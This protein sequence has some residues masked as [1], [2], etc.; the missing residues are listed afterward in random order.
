M[1]TDICGLCRRD[2]NLRDSHYL[3]A[4]LYEV[5]RKSSSPADPAPVIV[6]GDRGTAVFNSNQVS[7]PFLCSDCEDK[8]SKNGERVV[9][10]QCYRDEST[11]KLRDAMKAS[12]PSTSSSGRH[13]FYGNQ[14]RPAINPIAYYY[15]AL[16][17]FWRGSS[18]VWKPPAPNF[19]GV[20]G[21]RYQ[22]EVRKYLLGLDDQP[23]NIMVNVYVDYDPGVKAILGFPTTLGIQQ[24]NTLKCRVHSFLIPG[25]R[26]MIFVG[27]DTSRMLD[28]A[29]D[30][31]NL[32]F[33]TWRFSGTD[34]YLSLIHI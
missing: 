7:K 4:S 24:I 20:L 12:D 15:F 31:S 11:F 33:H 10:G 13:V 21:A 14:L 27:G 8:F 26:F 22:E 30:S 25:V 19:K 1:S 16:S 32:N 28:Q 9:V 5:V 6:D 29:S 17:V 34:F 18:T 2:K 3:P 23:E